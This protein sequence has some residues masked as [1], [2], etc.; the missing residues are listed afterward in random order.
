M[1]I[2]QGPNYRLTSYGRGWAYLLECTRDGRSVWFQ[3]DDANTFWEQL[4]AHEEANPHKPTDGVLAFMFGEYE[5]VA[6]CPNS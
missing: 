3:D 1:I 2:L 4:D 6:S 5:E